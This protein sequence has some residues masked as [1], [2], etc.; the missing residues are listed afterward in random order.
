MSFSEIIKSVFE[1]ED[2]I[3]LLKVRCV[4]M[5]RK[6]IILSICP[7]FI[8]T[9][10]QH[11][12]WTKI[13]VVFTNFNNL[14]MIRQHLSLFIGL[15]ICLIWIFVS[16]VIYLNF[17]FFIKY[18]RTEGFEVKDIVEEK[19]V[20][21]LFFL[22]LILPLSVNEIEEVNGLVSMI[23][24]VTIIVMLLAKTNLYYQNPI[25]TILNYRVYR[26]WFKENSNVKDIEYIGIG[27][28]KITGKNTVDYKI[29][30]DNVMVIKQKEERSNE[31]R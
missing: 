11:F 1:L 13:N 28:N 30:N 22:T 4:R 25:L 17:K 26:F 21:L 18:D 8:L 19:D 5:K 2:S 20:G 15:C 16:V 3:K 31:E 9:F 12:P 24:I 29:V 6:L 10:I 14:S 23:A 27:F 7:L